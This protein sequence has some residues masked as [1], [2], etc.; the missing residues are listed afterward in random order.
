M[1]LFWVLSF[2]LSMGML[3]AQDVI[4]AG[5]G[6]VSDS[7]NKTVKVWHNDNLLYEIASP[8]ADAFV[9]S[10]QI[11]ANR[12]Y[13][14]GYVRLTDG[15]HEARI[16]HNNSPLFSGTQGSEV[17]SLAMTGD[18]VYAA[19]YTSFDSTTMAATV[20]K[21][22]GLLFLLSDSTSNTKANA[23]AISGNNI[24]TAGYSEDSSGL[25]TALIWQNDSL[26]Y[27]L[28][29]STFHAEIIAV[30]CAGGQIYSAGNLFDA[31]GVSHA[32]AWCNDSLLYQLSDSSSFATAIAIEQGQV[33]IGGS[34]LGKAKIW[35]NGVAYQSIDGDTGTLTALSISDFGFFTAGK[36]DGSGKVWRNGTLLY[37]PVHTDEICGLSVTESCNGATRTL[38]WHESFEPYD[39][40]WLCWTQLDADSA[41]NTQNAFWSR[42]ND[43]SNDGAWSARH[44]KGD[45]LQEGWLISPKIYLQPDRDS[46]FLSFSSLELRP[47]DHG[48]SG[49][50]ISTT[51]TDTTDFEEIWNQDNAS[52][53]W[54]TIPIDLQS[55]QGQAVYLGFKYAGTNAHDWYIDNIVMDET[56]AMR[57][58]IHTFPYLENFDNALHDWY[59]VDDDHSGGLNNWKTG[60]YADSTLFA[61]HPA[62]DTIFGAQEGWLISR[63]IRLQQDKIYNLSFATKTSDSVSYRSS[64]L[65]VA[66]NTNGLPQTANFTQVWE[67]NA[68]SDEWK[69]VSLNLSSHAGHTVYLAFKYV[70]E[71]AHDFILDSINVEERNN[72]YTISVV[73]NNVQWGSTTG[74][75]TYPTFDTV[76]IAAT[77][78][79]GYEFRNWDDGNTENPRNIIVTQ[80][81]TYTANFGIIRYTITTEVLPESA[82]TVTGGGLYEVGTTVSLQAFANTGYSFTNWSDGNTDNPREITVNG[83]ATYIAVFES[84]QFTITTIANPIEGGTITGGGSYNYGD[85]AFLRPIPNEDFFFLCWSDG[86]V[87]NPRIVI[88]KNNAT[89]TALF[90]PKAGP[91][92]TVTVVSLNPELGSTTGSGSYAAGTA[93]EISAIPF[94]NAYFEKWS[95]GNTD[96]PR[97]VVVDTNLVFKAKFGAIPTFN[98]N[99]VSINPLMGTTFGSGNYPEGETVRIGAT[100]NPGYVFDHWDDGNTENP[101]NITVTGDMTYTAYFKDKPITTY[102]VTVY[103]NEE[104]GIVLGG[105][106]YPAGTTVHLAAIPNDGFVFFNWNDGVTDNPREIVVNHNM[107]FVAFFHGTGVDENGL[108]NIT[109]YPNPASDIIYLKGLDKAQEIEIFNAL[110]YQIR[111]ETIDTDGEIRISDL[112]SGLYLIKFE[113]RSLK[114]FKE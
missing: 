5:Y 32:A 91:N 50:W 46:T 18:T 74:S 79:S 85:T 59:V 1:R 102:T 45:S 89:Y 95:D 104:Q 11:G 105:G 60:M 108:G 93:I 30:T 81:Q 20:W 69:T 17:R 106:T 15:T 43:L 21:N 44:L 84:H 36:S 42:N 73:P 71:A 7:S 35:Q 97:H 38:P 94:E 52:G 29:D 76:Q 61:M 33:Y 86:I 66:D 90:Y 31:N 13:L 14:G 68:P 88:V 8:Q 109:L 16:W 62:A 39:S 57:D 23:I 63:P 28:G 58:T 77:P 56:F 9:K 37:S 82:G 78:F 49:L 10:M 99:V 41:N 54:K 110:G 111:K 40:D 64:S 70:G 4:Y 6:S 114:F 100:P 98:I 47:A 96:N 24:I 55:Y 72:E 27:T 65:W 103:Y 2:F 75:G 101:R 92:Y 25:K 67:E 107:E 53:N 113:N 22:N 112:S 83:D 51:G 26:L 3:S 48:Y 12:Q 34:V 87:S 80:N 19:G